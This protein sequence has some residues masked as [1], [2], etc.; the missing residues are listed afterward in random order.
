M[1]IH[2]LD[3]LSLTYYYIVEKRLI[4]YCPYIF[5]LNITQAAGNIVKAAYLLSPLYFYPQYVWIRLQVVTLRKWWTGVFL[6]NLYS[7]QVNSIQTKNE[8]H[9]YLI[10]GG[11]ENQGRQRNREKIRNT[12]VHYFPHH[13]WQGLTYFFFAHDTKAGKNV[14]MNPK[15]TKWS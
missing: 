2:T 7:S 15:C 3:V 5:T 9:L 13:F 1:Y 14:Q 4:I 12:R 10:N 11:S 6:F 8:A